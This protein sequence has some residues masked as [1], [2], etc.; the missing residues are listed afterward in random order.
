MQDGSMAVVVGEDDTHVETVVF[1]DREYE[2]RALLF[3][4]APKQK[5][6]QKPKPKPKAKHV[7]TEPTAT[8]VRPKPADAA[9]ASA[10]GP[11]PP[12]AYADPVVE[13]VGLEDDG[14]AYLGVRPDLAEIAEDPLRW[15]EALASDASPVLMISYYR[16]RYAPLGQTP[17]ER[18]MAASILLA[19]EF[20]IRATA[21]DPI[22]VQN[23]EYVSAAKTLISELDVMHGR[24]N[25]V[26]VAAANTLRT[27]YRQQSEPAWKMEVKKSTTDALKL[28]SYR[29][30]VFGSGE[31]D[32][33]PKRKKPR[34][35]GPR[36]KP[37]SSN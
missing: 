33:G 13:D 16:D 36:A 2:Y 11:E 25:K 31:D 35:K 8:K 14:D 21:R 15:P 5:T 24:R 4:P 34:S 9:T 7:A 1:P 12:A 28:Y 30:G 6:A 29:G 32:K 37:S 27:V 3:A 17:D 20:L 18:G 23:S 10:S 19:L 26:S 22:V